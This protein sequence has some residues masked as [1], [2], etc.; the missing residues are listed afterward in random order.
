VKY[1]TPQ[2]RGA[3]AQRKSKKEKTSLLRFSPASQRLCVEGFK[4]VSNITNNLIGEN[5]E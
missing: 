1:K 2:R 5:H 3:E 4:K